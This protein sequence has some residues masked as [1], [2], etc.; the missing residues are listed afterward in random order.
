MP[1][2]QRKSVHKKDLKIK[3]K[4]PPKCRKCKNHGISVN[5]KGHK[6]K[7]NYKHCPCDLCMN[8]EEVRRITRERIKQYRASKRLVQSNGM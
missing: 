2:N 3:R 4:S 5:V 1:K 8:T 6:L 7:C